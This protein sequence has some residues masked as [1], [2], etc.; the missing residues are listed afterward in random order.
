MRGPGFAVAHGQM[1]LD[2]FDQLFADAVKRVE[3]GERVLEHHADAL[4]AHLSHLLGVQ[5]VDTSAL[6]PDLAIGNPA[7]RFQEADDGGSGER[8]PAP[9]S[10]T[11][12]STSPGAMSNDTPSMAVRAPRR[13]GNSTRRFCTVNTGCDM[14]LTAVSG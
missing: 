9:D 1:G 4:A 8:L 3:T 7:G 11:T 10:P 5:V 14:P 2:G 12:P 13:I 6:Q